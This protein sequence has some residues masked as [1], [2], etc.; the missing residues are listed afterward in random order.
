M[1]TKGKMIKELKLRGVRKAKTEDGRD[2]SLEH[3]KTFE[4][5]KLY[6]EVTENA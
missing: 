2:V 3:L 1:L 6:F 5:T 4:V